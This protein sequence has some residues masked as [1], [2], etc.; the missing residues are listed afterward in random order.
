MSIEFVDINVNL[1]R[2]VLKGRLD[3]EGTEAISSEF[4]KLTSESKKNIIIDLSPV[5]FLASMGIRELITNAK[6][7]QKSGGRMVL[8]VGQN[9]LITKILETTNINKLLPMYK[10]EAEAEKAAFA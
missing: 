6:T 1:R 5:S 9:L 3:I 10:D 7:L 8:L 4:R 2:I